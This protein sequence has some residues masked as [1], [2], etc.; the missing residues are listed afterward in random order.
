MDCQQRIFSKKNS[1]RELNAFIY[2]SCHLKI[3]EQE[4][5]WESQLVSVAFPYFFQQDF[6]QQNLLY[7]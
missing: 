6:G 5:T 7:T 4:R 3:F 2:V 1:H